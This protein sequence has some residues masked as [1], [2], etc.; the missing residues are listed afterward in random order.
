M[1]DHRHPSS[2]LQPAELLSSAP[3][4]PRAPTLSPTHVI[5]PVHTGPS[6]QPTAAHAAASRAA[7]DHNQIRWSLVGRS[8]WV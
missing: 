6:T 1:V 5:T 2:Q 4:Q 8:A 7:G 3:Q